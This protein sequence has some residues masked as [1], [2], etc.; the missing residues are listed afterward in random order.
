MMRRIL[1]LLLVL[2][3]MALAADDFDHDHQRWNAL[4]QEHVVWI[5]GGV[6]SQVDYAALAADRPSLEAYLEDLS[7]V[8]ESQY[9]QWSDDQQLAFLINAYNAFTVELILRQ[10]PDLDSIKDLGGWISS[11]W[12]K[13]FF[14]LRGAQ[15]SLDEVEH[16]MIRVEFAEPRIHMAV[17]CASVGCPALADTA[18]VAPRLDAQLER[19]VERFMSDP[20]RNRYDKSANVFQVSKIFDW[21]GDDWNAGSGYDGGVREFLMAHLDRLSQGPPPPRAQVRSAD[22]EYLDY[23]WSLN[24]IQETE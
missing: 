20:S 17:N 14:R 6:A 3:V 21:Y 19:A 22:I 24:D 5:D 8:S 11:P 23:D 1:A 18:Y 12:D 13:S 9:Q 7:A 16:G 2:P 10:Y 4:L 15:R